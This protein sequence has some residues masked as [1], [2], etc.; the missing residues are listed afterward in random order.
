ML[1]LRRLIRSFP[2]LSLFS[3]AIFLRSAAIVVWGWRLWAPTEPFLMVLQIAVLWEA[4]RRLASEYPNLGSAGQVVGV[5]GGGAAF[6]AAVLSV[7]SGWWTLVANRTVNIASCA[8]LAAVMVSF[9]LIPIP[10]RKNTGRHIWILAALFITQF[11]RYW[12]HL[13]DNSLSQHLANL[14]GILA[15]AFCLIAWAIVLTPAGEQEPPRRI[16]AAGEMETLRE[17]TSGMLGMLDRLKRR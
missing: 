6:C 1:I 9:L 2:I 5:I 12:L 17:Q 10:I 13:T 4:S 14:A 15:E 8:W 7:R 11:F 3:L 16:A